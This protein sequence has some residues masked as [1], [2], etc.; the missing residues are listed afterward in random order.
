DFKP[1]QQDYV[2]LA[3]RDL[4]AVLAKVNFD[5]KELLAQAQALAKWD[6]SLGVDSKEGVLYAVW[7][8]EVKA[9]M[10]ALHLPK[11]LQKVCAELIRL[12]V[13]FKALTDADR[14]WFGDGSKAARDRLVRETFA[15]A[16]KQRQK[17]PQRWGA[18]HTV[19]FR[20]PLG[21]VSPAY[22]K[23]FDLGPT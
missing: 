5:D 16:A 2:S 14:R 13:M 18:L 12:P 23:A 4:V 3:A 17:L 19:T 20:H 9:A 8:K 21:G 22:A 7:L 6:G 1:L 10:L 15:A 11:D